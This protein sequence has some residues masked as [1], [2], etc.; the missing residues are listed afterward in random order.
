MHGHRIPAYERLEEF[1]FL[2]DG[3]SNF[4]MY[5]QKVEKT[6]SLP[7]LF[8]L[9]KEACMGDKQAMRNILAFR[10]YKVPG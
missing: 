4:D 2:V 7:F 3:R 6:P 1:S 10:G 8:P 5:R 9:V